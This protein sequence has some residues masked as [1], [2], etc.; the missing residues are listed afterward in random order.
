MSVSAAPATAPIDRGA[1]RYRV[2]YSGGK[3]KGKR[4]YA[5]IEGEL[6]YAN[7]ARYAP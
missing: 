5:T 6:T 2:H 4:R 3:R 7:A 1:V